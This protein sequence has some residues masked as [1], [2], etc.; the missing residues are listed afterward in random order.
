MWRI[1][2]EL[3]TRSETLHNSPD[4]LHYIRH[5]DRAQRRVMV[6]ENSVISIRFRKPELVLPRPARDRSPADW[7]LARSEDL[8]G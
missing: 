3:V 1:L 7:T 4:S 2:E 5:S 6:R 8:R